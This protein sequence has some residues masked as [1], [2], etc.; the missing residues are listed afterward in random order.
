MTFTIPSDP[1]EYEALK[2]QRPAAYQTLMDI[3]ELGER[4]A[5]E[6]RQ[7]AVQ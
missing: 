3:A 4:V 1:R 7:G 6:L 2:A 5:A